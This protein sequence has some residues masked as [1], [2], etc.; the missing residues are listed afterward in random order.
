MRLPFA[1]SLSRTG[2]GV[3]AQLMIAEPG[4]RCRTA[5]FRKSDHLEDANAVV[6]RER[7][8]A[9]DPHR[10]ARLGD[11]S[12]VDPDMAGLDQPLREAAA[13][14]QPDAMEVAVD[15]QRLSA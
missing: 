12:A 6:E 9:A 8:R 5:A 15:P 1:R 13:L 3:N 4:L 7:D 11:A 14:H 2:I 10:L